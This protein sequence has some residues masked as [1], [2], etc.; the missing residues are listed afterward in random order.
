MT[1]SEEPA[2]PELRVSAGI[3]I[4]GQQVVVHGRDLHRDCLEMSYVNYLLFCVTGRE[5]EPRGV[6]VLEQLWIAT[7]YPDARIW[8][9]RIAGYMG[10]ARVDPGLAMSAAIAASN[11]RAYGF[12]AMRMAYDVQAAMSGDETA[13][14][15]WLER[16]LASGRILPG[17][18]RPVHAHDE[19]I[20][21][22]L[23]ALDSAGL[24]AGP[25]LRRAFWLDRRLRE[26]KGI[27]MNIAAVW[28]A[29]A[30][31]FGIDAREYEAFML[32]MFAPGYMAVYAEQRTKPP[33][34]FLQ[35]YQTRL[36]QPAVHAPPG[37]RLPS[38][39]LTARSI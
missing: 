15:E 18:G 33:F 21:Y 38:T 12:R 19:R 10:S 9:N 28:A 16:E 32:L 34:A 23:A 30:I 6:R 4:L 31:D 24:A 26:R 29:I 11:S 1:E 27:E 14:A 13:R 5:F 8:C 2:C 22:A 39:E 25:A 7:G 3:A 35:G 37:S 36:R 17:Y 20:G